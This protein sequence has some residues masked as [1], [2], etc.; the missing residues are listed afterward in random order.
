MSVRDSF[1]PEQP[2]EGSS[3]PARRKKRHQTLRACDLCRRKKSDG[4]DGKKIPCTNCADYDLTCT[5]GTHQYKQPARRIIIADGPPK[6]YTDA[7]ERR[8]RQVESLLQERCPDVDLVAEFGTPPADPTRASASDPPSPEPSPS[9]GGQGLSYVDSISLV[10]K[11]II[12]DD[13][14]TTVA[15]DEDDGPEPALRQSTSKLSLDPFESRYQ[16]KAHETRLFHIIKDIK[17]NYNGEP[18]RGPEAEAMRP[19]FPIIQPWESVTPPVYHS[20]YFF[21]DPDLLARLVDAY[22]DNMNIYFPAFHRMSFVKSVFQ[23]GL[24]LSN[25]AF[26]ATLL[27]MCAVGSRFMADDPRVLTDNSNSP[28][29]A[30]WAFFRQVSDGRKITL[31]RPTLFDVQF[32]LVAGQ[33]LAWSTAPQAG[34]IEAGRGLRYAEDVGAH[35]RAFYDGA[36]TPALE[37]WKRT[38]WSLIVL[39]VLLG[40]CLGRQTALASNQYDLPMPTP[41]DDEHWGSELDGYTWKQP[42]NVKSVLAGF[43]IYI[44]IIRIQ[45]VMLRTIYALK[46]TRRS[47]GLPTSYD[48]KIMSILDAALDECMAQAPPHIQWNPS[49]ADPV[50]FKYTTALHAYVQ[51]VRIVLHRPFIPSR[52]EVSHASLVACTEAA[53]SIARMVEVQRNRSGGHA[54]LLILMTFAAGIVLTL[55]VWQ[56]RRSGALGDKH[57]RFYEEALFCVSFFER[58][59]SIWPLANRFKDALKE[60]LSIEQ[61]PSPQEEWRQPPDPRLPVP[62][63]YAAHGDPLRH[64]FDSVSSATSSASSPADNYTYNQPTTFGGWP[65]VPPHPNVDLSPAHIPHRLLPRYGAAWETPQSEWAQAQTHQRTDQYAN[66]PAL[67]VDDWSSYIHTFRQTGQSGGAQM[68]QAHQLGTHRSHSHNGGDAYMNMM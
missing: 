27:A 7:L 47:A 49:Q 13:D 20:Q 46:P 8:L 64:S 6:R 30:G 11:S 16:N 62:S 5:Y 22:F 2:S 17:A 54:P 56:C 44:K 63:D 45:D 68:Q 53:H 58:H 12:E 38:V 21:P 48:P 25:Q 67:L 23:D 35:R 41:V 28:A 29:S 3:A 40:G 50:L 14:D 18:M 36:H 19:H 57:D 24:H 42:E 59:E 39:E 9:G 26:G 32:Q 10:L 66:A 52:I 61:Y 51:Y 15:D 43:N 33:F 1:P 60:L 65:L 31:A 37:V 55:N 34:W 4:L